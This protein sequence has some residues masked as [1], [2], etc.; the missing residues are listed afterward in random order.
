MPS[1][2]MTLLCQV[3]C[4]FRF[5]FL[6]PDHRLATLTIQGAVAGVTQHVPAPMRPARRLG[7]PIAEPYH[8]P[9]Y[10]G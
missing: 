5:Q 6:V 7:L 2:H 9:R 1:V 8:H 3:I 10:Q 4:R